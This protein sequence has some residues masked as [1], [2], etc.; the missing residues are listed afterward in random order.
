MRRQ[1][2]SVIFGVLIAVLVIYALFDQRV[3]FRNIV[4]VAPAPQ[5]HTN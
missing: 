2:A 5:S 1:I 3:S 4:A